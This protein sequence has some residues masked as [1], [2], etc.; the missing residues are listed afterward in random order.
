[1]VKGDSLTWLD[2]STTDSLGNAV[3]SATWVLT[4]AIRGPTVLTLTGSASGDGWTTSITAAQS[5]AFTTGTYFWQAYATKALERLTL[6]S[7]SFKVQDNLSTA[8]SGFDGRT[9]SKQD[10]DAVQAAMRA[11]I[12]GGAVQDYVI[13][14]RQVKK[15]LMADLIKLEAKLKAD[16]VRETKAS[17]IANGLGNP[18]NMYVRF[19]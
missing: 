11:M 4:Y 15:M 2:A 7:G 18:H 14:N 6:S 12:S 9:Q 8:T 19:N 1:M 10:L 3:T 16:V 13:G 5:G 17:A